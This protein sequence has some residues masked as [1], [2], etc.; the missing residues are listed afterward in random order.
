MKFCKD[1]RHRLANPNVSP[2]RVEMSLCSHRDARREP[3]SDY[4]VTGEGEPSRPPFCTTMRI[5]ENS[6]TQCGKDGAWFEP[7]AA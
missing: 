2:D 3:V 7:V 6:P 4:A 5:G 1:C